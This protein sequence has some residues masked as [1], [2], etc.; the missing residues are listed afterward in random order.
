MSAVIL[1]SFNTLKFANRLKQ[2]GVPEAQAEVEAEMLH[3][4]L[5][6]RD[7]ALA[8]LDGKFTALEGNVKH[9]TGEMISK[10]DLKAAI[11]GVEGKISGLQTEMSGVKIEIAEMRGDIKLLKWMMG[12]M[13]AGIAS[14]L[15]K[16]FF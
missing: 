4:A 16:T 7:Q 9:E 14:L 15:V 12:F 1:P 11:S 6:A 8:A 13:L 5:D 10:E 2:A 3:E